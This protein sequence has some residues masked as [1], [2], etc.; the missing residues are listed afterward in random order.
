MVR[1]VVSLF[2]QSLIYIRIEGALGVDCKVA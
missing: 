2:A 1:G